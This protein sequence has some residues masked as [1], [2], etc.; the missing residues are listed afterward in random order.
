MVGIH[1]V[2]EYY[3][4]KKSLLYTLSSYIITALFLSS[5]FLKA[6]NIYEVLKKYQKLL[7]NNVPG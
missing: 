5:I 6:L 7:K 3:K 2:M 4:K 1:K